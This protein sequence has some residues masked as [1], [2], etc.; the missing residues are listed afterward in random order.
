M[1]RIRKKGGGGVHVHNWTSFCSFRKICFYLHTPTQYILCATETLHTTQMHQ[2]GFIVNLF[3]LQSEC[4]KCNF[5]PWLPCR[6]TFLQ[7]IQTL[8]LMLHRS[9]F[10]CNQNPRKDTGHW[11]KHSPESKM[12]SNIDGVIPLFG[13]L[14]NLS[15]L[16]KLCFSF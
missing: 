12:P 14:F 2:E 5:F 4:E 13:P 11:R 16:L 3:S 9:V 1:Y 15:S 10:M 6:D 7:P 8:F